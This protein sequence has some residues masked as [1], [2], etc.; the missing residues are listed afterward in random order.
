MKFMIEE[1]ACH[2]CIVAITRAIRSMDSEA[3]VSANL[4]DKTIVVVGWLTIGDALRVMQAAGYPAVRVPDAMTASAAV[5]RRSKSP[6]M[7]PAIQRSGIGT[8]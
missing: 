7:K 8:N 2:H 6:P 3:E 1:M 5:S 4:T